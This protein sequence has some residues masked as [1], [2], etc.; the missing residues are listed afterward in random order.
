MIRSAE[1][2]TRCDTTVASTSSTNA[3]RVC[4]FTRYVWCQLPPLPPIPTSSASN[5]SVIANTSSNTGLASASNANAFASSS[6][7]NAKKDIVSGKAGESDSIVCASEISKNAFV[8]F[9]LPTRLP[10]GRH[11]LHRRRSTKSSSTYEG[12]AIAFVKVT[13]PNFCCAL[14]MPHRGLIRQSKSPTIRFPRDQ[15]SPLPRPRFEISNA[16]PRV[17]GAVSPKSSSRCEPIFFAIRH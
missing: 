16:T 6:S 9:R 15:S 5:T 3:S 1:I 10:E 8:D 2:V 11:H 17:G 12:I 13:K 4:L 7:P 14:E